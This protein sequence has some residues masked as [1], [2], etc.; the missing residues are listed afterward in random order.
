MGNLKF[1]ELGN[2]ATWELVLGY[3]VCER[4]FGQELLKISPFCLCSSCGVLYAL[5]S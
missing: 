1:S 5:F 3:P 4:C 2:F